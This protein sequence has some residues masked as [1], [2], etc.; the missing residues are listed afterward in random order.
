MTEHKTAFATTAACAL[1]T[2]MLGYTQAT[3]V[4]APVL[5]VGDNWVFERTIDRGPD[6]VA[7]R[8]VDLRINRI[9]ENAML[10]RANPRG[11]SAIDHDY[12]V[13]LDWTQS[14]VLDGQL[15]VTG[16]PFKFPMAP[17]DSW[18][19]EFQQAESH[20]GQT[21]THWNV[22]YQVVG[23]TDVTTPAGTFHALEI[24]ETGSTEAEKTIAQ[25]VSSTTAA[26]HRRPAARG[27][28]KHTLRQAIKNTVYGEFYYVPSIKYYVK[29]FQE[30]YDADNVRTGREEDVLL[31]FKPGAASPPHG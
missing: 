27:Q 5:E 8:R 2:P 14:R 11:T 25:Q 17:G 15:A 16:R 21:N 7:H 10:V 9:D 19:V 28:A 3:A 13:G 18:T 31:S 12:R 6:H 23:W 26:R 20:N 4:V 29:Y 1:L 30:Q 22:L 24:K